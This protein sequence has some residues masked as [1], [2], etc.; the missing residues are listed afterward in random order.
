MKASKLKFL[1]TAKRTGLFDLARRRS[2]TGVRILNYH[3]IWTGSDPYAGDSMFFTDTGFTRRLELIRAWG[4][5]VVSLGD[6]IDHLS[7]QKAIPPNAVVITIDD[8]WYSSYKDMFP[9]LHQH[10]MPFTLYCDTGHLYTPG[11]I[12]HVAAMYFKILANQRNDQSERNIALERPLKSVATDRSRSYA[13]RLDATEKL[14][15]LLGFDF[16]RYMADKTFHYMSP[17][18]LVEA[19]SNP[20]VSI[21]LH[22]HN[23]TLRDWSRNAIEQEIALNRAALA[24]LLKRPPTS[25]KHFCYPS[26]EYTPEAAEIIKSLG[27]KS[28]TTTNQGIATVG[29]SLL[30]LPRLCDNEML[31]EIEFEAELS[32][33][34]DWMR[35][36][37][38][39][40]PN[41]KAQSI[42][43]TRSA[44]CLA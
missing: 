39:V 40:V 18:E 34:A 35:L 6:A 25:F 21:E 42:G 43:T 38:T 37:R 31:T 13:E 2:S 12:P 17:S 16:T 30:M 24:D 14:A 41:S 36:S 29:T 20:D 7:G 22:T 32:G 8:G 44:F 33:F 15:K 3:G 26:G 1:E 9:K 11:V 4:Y 10:G 27:I 23:H 19:A 5:P 28:A